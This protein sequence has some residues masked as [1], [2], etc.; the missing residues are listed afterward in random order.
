MNIYFGGNIRGRKAA[1]A[2]VVVENGEVRATTEFLN[3][4]PKIEA[5]YEGLLLAISI[6]KKTGGSRPI[7]IGTNKAVADQVNGFKTPDSVRASELLAK[8]HS[9]LSNLDGWWTVLCLPS[10]ENY[11]AVLACDMSIDES[12]SFHLVSSEEDFRRMAA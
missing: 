6:Y 8:V 4:A 7:F 3:D 2:A 11:F 10:Y 9:A 1:A 5:E 12:S